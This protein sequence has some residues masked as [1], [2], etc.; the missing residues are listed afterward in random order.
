MKIPVCEIF[1]YVESLSIDGDVRFNIGLPWSGLVH[2]LSF[3]GADCE[4]KVV[5][6]F[7]ELI[8]AVLQ[9]ALRAQSSANRRLLMV[10]VETLVFAR[11]LLM[12][13]ELTR[14][15]CI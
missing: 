1:H 13:K 10:F 11:G 2:H 14:H 8:H 3:L 15:T 4:P 6:G 9:G 5:A 7:R 12:L